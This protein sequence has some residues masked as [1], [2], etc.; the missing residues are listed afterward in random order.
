MQEIRLALYRMGGG[1]SGGGETPVSVHRVKEQVSRAPNY[2]ITP[3]I[4]L[5]TIKK[6]RP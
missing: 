4:F 6:Q 1:H 3:A 5:K 2:P